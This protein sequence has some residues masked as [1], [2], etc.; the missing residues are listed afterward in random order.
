MA[1]R[2]ARIGLHARNDY[3]F[4]EGDYLVIQEARIET[5]KML[6][7]TQNSVFERVRRENPDLEFIVRLH[8]SRIGPT[9]PSP[10][11][12]VDAA[13]PRINDL[14]AFA[15]KFEILNEP[16]HSE[17][18]EGWGSS[19]AEAR[20]FRDWYLEALSRLRR[21]CPW[22]KFGFPGL[23]PHWPHR[24]LEWLDICREAVEA[25]DWLG[26]HIYWQHDNQLKN[27]WGLR[28][29]AYHKMFP[30]K[31]IEITEFGNSTPN[32]SGDIVAVQYAMF[33]QELFKYPYL[34]SASAFLASSAD[35]QWA[36]FVWRKEFG[37]LRP[38]VRVTGN[39]P[40]PSLVAPTLITPTPPYKVDWLN[41]A[42]PPRMVAG[43]RAAVG[44]KLKNAGTRTWE[45]NRVRIACRWYE[46]QGKSVNAVEDLYTHLPANVGTGMILTLNQVQLS[47]PPVPGDFMLKWDLL[48]GD[49]AWFSSK[50]SP[51]LDIDATVEP[52]SPSEGLYFAEAQCTVSGAF[53]DF[54]RKLGPELCGHAVT[55]SFREN[56]V[57]VQYF[58]NVAMEEHAP[59]QI[60]LKPM[61]SEAHAAYAKIAELE[62]RNKALEAEIARLQGLS[63]GLTT[64]G[65]DILVQMQDITDSLPKHETRTYA[66]RPLEHIRD[67][68]IHHTAVSPDVGPAAIARY[69][70]K[71]KE[72]PGI[73]YHFLIMADGTTFQANC[74]ETISYHAR[75]ANPSSIGIA[76]AGNFMEDDP[77]AAQLES[78]G[79]LL[80]YLMQKLDLNGDRIRGH[81]DFVPTACPGSQWGTGSTWHDRLLGEANKAIYKA[82][83][84]HTRNIVTVN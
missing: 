64:E 14:R 75:Q 8:D 76:F 73:G 81:R 63:D 4:A 83:I 46:L 29:K 77:T 59:G 67:F 70:V 57:P 23:A 18:Y 6:S 38:M 34:G 51:T 50:G 32:L 9:H 74:L 12:F 27:D 11:A 35:P 82:D 66:S 42:P 68:I 65:G 15:V 19:D 45:A 33:Y 22:A 55:N 7:L 16:N 53:L 40:R 49:D 37:E 78:G 21:A 1:D 80:A 62:G 72:W 3:T 39:M 54:Y 79:R 47:M 2:S 60:R 71:R 48:E 13:I 20:S 84:I 25:S 10:E 36:L 24:D 43:Q 58:Q 28:F 69:H 52:L 17:G 5:L 56:G 30:D 41:Y 44:I 61:G 31:V 26:C